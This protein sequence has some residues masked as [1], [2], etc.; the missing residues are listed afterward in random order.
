MRKITFPH[1]GNM[2]IPLKALFEKMGFT[3]IVPPLCTNRTLELGVKYSPEF[4]CLPLKINIGNFIEALELGADTIIMAGGIGPCRFGYYGEVQREI[5]EN[6]GYKF[7]MIVL[8]PPKGHFLDLMKKI[9][10]I[11]NLKE[12]FHATQIAWNKGLLLDE[13][14]KLSFKI[15]PIELNR[16]ETD[17]VYNQA[18]KEIEKT[19]TIEDLS[20]LKDEIEMK[21]NSIARNKS[22]NPPKVGLVGEIY[23]VLEPFVNIQIEKQ[24]GG[25]GVEVKRSIYITDWIRENL[26]PAI[27]KPREHKQLL[28]LAKPYINCFIGGH[29]QETVA[30]VV[31]FSKHDYDGVIQLLPFTC[32]PEIVAKSV[33][34]KVSQ[35]H[36]IS[37]MTLV[38]DEHTAET[39][40]ITRLEAFVDMINHKKEFNKHEMFIGN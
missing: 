27:F 8:E 32:M 7:E 13:V 20:N 17:S 37:V 34:P 25:L 3:V 19:N 12:L 16:G 21:F 15:R 6:L 36:D 40:L 29:G 31:N 28:E 9:R 30:Q 39:G 35:N 23:T 2:H 5:L 38:L 22:K 18:L 11:F 33:L 1:M 10:S 14:D 26:F 24:L 4:A